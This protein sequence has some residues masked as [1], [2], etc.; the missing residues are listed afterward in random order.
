MQGISLNQK[1]LY[2]LQTKRF[3]CI[4]FLQNK[5]QMSRSLFGK[6]IKLIVSDMAGSTINE[7]GIIYRSLYQ[8][9]TNLGFPATEAQ[10]KSWHGRD[11]VEVMQSHIGKECTDELIEKAEG[12]LLKELQKQYFQDSNVTLVHPEL[13]NQL[14]EFQAQG[15]K[16]ALNT[17]Y[18]IIMQEQIINHFSM[19]EFVDTWISSESVPF[20]RPYPFMVHRLMEECGIEKVS[21]VAKIGDTINDMKEGKN[22]GCGL[23][24][25]V[26]SGAGT[27]E[28]LLENGADVVLN[29]ISELKC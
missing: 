26:L 6:N 22:A 1:K 14:Q 20:G 13:K 10:Q 4:F 25:G 29:N 7:G 16:I 3:I 19:E 27:R 17:G 23:V 9:M 5:I 18:P 2:F 12:M 11:K 21:E 15:I 8:T 24:I 28:E